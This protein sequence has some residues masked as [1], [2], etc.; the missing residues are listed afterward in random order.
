VLGRPASAVLPLDRTVPGLQDR[1]RL[2][3]PRGRLGREF[4][5]LASQLTEDRS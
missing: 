5:R 1:G 4:T 2:A 3:S